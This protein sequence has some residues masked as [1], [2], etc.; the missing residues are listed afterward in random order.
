MNTESLR[1]GI[2]KPTSYPQA[3]N[4]PNKKNKGS[5]ESFGKSFPKNM[6]SRYFLGFKQDNGFLR[7]G[8]L[9]NDF[10][11][12]CAHSLSMMYCDSCAAFSLPVPMRFFIWS[13]GAVSGALWLPRLWDAPDRKPPQAAA[14]LPSDMNIPARNLPKDHGRGPYSSGLRPG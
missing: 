8:T 12:C 4:P 1:F 10:E 13:H 3:K 9:S 11:C 2:S 5:S 6:M 14:G 7:H